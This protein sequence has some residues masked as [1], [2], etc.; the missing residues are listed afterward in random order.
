[1][2]RYPE[3]ER[4][5]HKYEVQKIEDNVAMDTGDSENSLAP[6]DPALLGA[7][8][9][10]DGKWASCVRLFNVHENRT[11]DLVELKDNEAAVSM[12]TCVFHERMDEVCYLFRL[13]CDSGVNVKS[14]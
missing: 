12:C 14:I 13:L 8:P 11:L 10:G 5:E 7:P 6:I 2:L 9:A 1:M 3:A 4:E